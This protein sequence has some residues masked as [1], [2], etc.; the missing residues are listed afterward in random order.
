[1]AAISSLDAQTVAAFSFEVAA[2]LATR[3]S[4]TLSADRAEAILAAI[5]HLSAGAGVRSAARC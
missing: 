1:M 4:V 3:A 2:A 5:D